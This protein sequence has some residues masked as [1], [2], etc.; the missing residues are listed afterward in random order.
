M[1]KLSKIFKGTFKSINEETKTATVVVS[2]NSVD[3]D[4]EIIDPKAFKKRL[5]SYLAH[6]ILLSSHNPWDLENQLGEA[7]SV[8][9]TDTGVEVEFEWYAGKT[10]PD[11]RS[12]NPKA[13][14]AW[15]LAQKKIAAFSVGMRVFEWQDGQR[16]SDGTF[17]NGVRRTFTDVEL[18]EI[19]QVLIP[20]NRDA[21]Q[22]R[23]G[24][25]DGEEAEL[26]EMAA[27]SIK[28]EE[29]PEEPKAFQITQEQYLDIKA[30]I[31]NIEES[32]K[33]IDEVSSEN[34]KLQEQISGLKQKL[35]G[36][37]LKANESPTAADVKSWIEEAI[38]TTK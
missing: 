5:G 15:F 3:R 37:G 9:I 21:M 13:D 38:K 2:T 34:K 12:L 31:S 10:G 30:S 11:G 23:R 35:S 6:P 8:N 7:K 27:K 33:I 20:A 17:V 36:E 32:I 24:K 4:N 25:A 1:S 28:D 22:T 26:L 19:S 18:L 16:N 14:W 29:W